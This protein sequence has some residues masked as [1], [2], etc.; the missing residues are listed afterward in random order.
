MKILVMIF[1]WVSVLSGAVDINTAG[2]KELS[3]LN[4]IGT[5]KADAIIAY[6]SVNCFK[7]VDELAKV[8]GIGK[9]TIQKN[10]NNLTTSECKR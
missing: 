4:G 7:S 5:K 2:Q 8:K 6:R 1:L 9:K 10:R 3:S